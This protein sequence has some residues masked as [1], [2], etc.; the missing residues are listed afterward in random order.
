MQAVAMANRNGSSIQVFGA[1]ADP[2]AAGVGLERGQPLHH[3]RNLVGVGTMLP[4][5]PSFQLARRC[6]P[7]LRVLGAAFNPAET[8]SQV[9][10]K[11]ARS[12]T[13][14]LGLQLVEANVENTVAVGDAVKSLISRGVQAIWVPGDNT[15]AASMGQVIAICREAGIP[16]ISIVPGKPDRGTLIDCGIDFHEAGRL[17]GTV[18][19]RILKGEDP[20]RIPIQDA[21]D[22]VRHPITVNKLAL[23]GLKEA[24]QV[25]DDLA[26]QADFLVDETG[27][28]TREAR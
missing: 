24:W 6:L 20:M 1:V 5:E 15:M 11:Q 18:A 25:P 21:V 2:Y 10:M 23:N 3:P 13:A 7:G 4:V 12:V 26:R 16:A 8:N 9:F 22:M 17:T 19:A 28:H 27:T 14:K